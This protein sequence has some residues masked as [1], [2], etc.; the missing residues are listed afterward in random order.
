MLYVSVVSRESIGVV[1]F[2]LW[3]AFELHLKRAFAGIEIVGVAHSVAE[4]QARHSCRPCT[5]RR[6][7]DRSGGSHEFSETER[8]RLDLEIR[9]WAPTRLEGL[10][11]R[12]KKRRGERSELGW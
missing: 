9:S 6:L 3:A 10:F 4:Q 11:S 1:A 7:A 2:S 8:V 5:K 12:R